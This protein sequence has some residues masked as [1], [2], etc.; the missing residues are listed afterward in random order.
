MT[1]TEQSAAYQ[2]V[3]ATHPAVA[4]NPTDLTI[5]THRMESRLRKL[6]NSELLF[7]MSLATRGERAMTIRILHHLNEIERRRLYLEQGCSS[8]FDYCTRRLKYSSSAA[9]RRIHSARCIKRHPDVLEMLRARDLNLSTIS[10]IAPILDRSN[11]ATILKRVRGK[12]YREVERVASEYRPPVALRDRV[13]PVR[14]PVS[15]PVDADAVLLDRDLNNLVRGEATAGAERTRVGTQQKMF[16]Q[17]LASEELMEKFEEA[18][19][20]LSHRC[21]DGSFAEVLDVLVTEFVERHSPE[22]RQRR[23]GQRKSVAVRPQRNPGTPAPGQEHSPRENE[24]TNSRRHAMGTIH[25]RRRECKTNNLARRD[26]RPGQPRADPRKVDQPQR[27]RHVPAAVRDEVFVRDRG[28]CAFVTRY[29]KRCGSKK[30]LQ[31]DHVH[32]FAA[33]GT[34]DPLNLQLL[35]AAHNRMAAEQTLG[36]HIM[37]RFWR[38]E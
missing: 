25:S 18:R 31:I 26:A 19:A 17:F 37:K 21:L 9:A 10:L 33:G 13:R 23:R 24:S 38:R 5:P 15:E 20:L 2:P 3:A 27:S 28:A 1:C 35:C 8:L 29:G 32:P 11:E 6:S 30:R 22:A 12:S 36:K 4:T 7:R 16:V 14:V 34:H